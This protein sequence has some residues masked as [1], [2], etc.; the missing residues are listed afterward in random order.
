MYLD[1]V[2]KMTQIERAIQGLLILQEIDP[3]ATLMEIYRGFGVRLSISALD[4]VM[5]GEVIDQRLHQLGWRRANAWW[6]FD[7]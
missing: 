1:G 3:D 2:G 4:Q 7:L 6:M 5:V